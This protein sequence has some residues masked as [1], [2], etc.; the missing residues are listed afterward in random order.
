MVLEEKRLLLRMLAPLLLIHLAA[1]GSPG[2]ERHISSDELYDKLHGMWVGQLIGNAAGRETE[3]AYAGPES[4]PAESVPWV[5]KHIWD[6]DDDTDIEYLALHILETHGFECDATAIADEWLEHL[7]AEG[8]YMANKQA[9]HLMLDGYLPPDTG[10]RTFNQ[11]W[12][13]ID[14]QI[15][16]EVLGALSPGM[17]QVAADLCGRFAR[18]T[19][20]GHAVHAAQFYAVLYSEAFLESDIPTLIE[21]GLAAIP[22][23]SRAAQVVSDVLAWHAEDLQDGAPDWRATRGELYQY[24]QGPSS[25]GRYYNWAESTIN[26]GATM[27]A[28]LYGAGDF[29]ETTQIAVLAGWD[30]DCNPATAAGLIGIIEGYSGLPPELTDPAQCGDAYLNVTRPGLP[31]SDAPLPQQEAI[32]GIAQRMHTL[33]VENIIR[34]GGSLHRARPADFFLLPAS[35]VSASSHSAVGLIG[36]PGLLGQAQAAGI[37]VTPSAS[38]A[39]YNEAYDRHNLHTI[40]DG[41]RDNAVTGQRPYCTALPDPA[42]GPD[43]DWYELSFSAPVLL[44]GLNLYEGDVLW[45]NLNRY[46]R[47]DIARGGYFDDLTVEV[48]IDG[49]YE[50]PEELTLGTCPDPLVMYQTLDFRFTPVVADAI[51][52][53]GSPGGSDAFTTILE[54]EPIGSLAAGPEL[55]AVT[56][57]DLTTSGEEPH[58]LLLV[59]SEPLDLR[60][61]ALSL[62]ALPYGI[63]V[64]LD[65]AELLQNA[66]RTKALLTLCERLPVGAYRLEVRCDTATASESLPSSDHG[67]GVHAPL[68]A[69]FSVP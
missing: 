1:L 32:S 35:I 22:A 19:N 21:T 3:G 40:I 56:L 37:T 16:T 33:A 13:S 47:L 52:V 8:L 50:T 44:C 20:A 34:N 26:L 67:S 65:D 55:L 24:Y 61:E 38:V 57:A 66:P 48:R 12:Y 23:E 45:S 62:Q 36:L 30:S 58:K 39:R 59:F 10:S 15:G 9:W 64:E 18:V 7:T 63:P 51:R 27:L 4:N 68:T 42:Q 2:A 49:H 69:A 28:L 29:A 5:I 25:F 54:L 17:P 11:H 6:A 53:I 14:A 41:I 46:R 43:T 31:D 60:L